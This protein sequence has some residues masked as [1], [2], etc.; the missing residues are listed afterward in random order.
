VGRE[1]TRYSL[2][3]HADSFLS[4]FSRL[5]R[6]TQ[7]ITQQC[8]LSLSP[9][10]HMHHRMARNTAQHKSVNLLKTLFKNILIL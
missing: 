8:A 4:D 6:C 3:D 7:A 1:Q 5:C 9:A 10:G 2:E